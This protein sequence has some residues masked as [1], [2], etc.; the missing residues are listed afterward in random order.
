MDEQSPLPTAY[1]AAYLGEPERPATP[2]AY[3]QQLAARA[4][5]RY[6]YLCLLTTLDDPTDPAA[7]APPRQRL[8]V[9]RAQLNTAWADAVDRTLLAMGEMYERPEEG[10]CDYLRF[11]ADGTVISA[12]IAS[13]GGNAEMANI[14]RWFN[15]KERPN[16][17]WT[18]HADQLSF[19]IPTTFLMNPQVMHNNFS[20]DLEGWQELCEKENAE[21]MR[22]SI[23]EYQGV[24]GPRTLA[25]RSHSRI[26]GNDA[27]AIYRRTTPP[28][29]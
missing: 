19:F 23:I 4:D 6:E 10:H 24:V 8:R 28:P 14:E 2:L 20:G 18:L 29:A 27:I 16:G 1:L 13:F 5:P 3:I 21:T 22:R 7:G 15:R 9:L 11:Y 25:L 26:N 17:R 12:P